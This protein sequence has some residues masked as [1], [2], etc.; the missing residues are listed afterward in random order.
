MASIAPVKTFG[1]SKGD[2]STYVVTWTPITNAD[3]CIA[4]SA[5]EYSDRSVHVSGTFGGTSIAVQGSNN[6]GVSFAS[7]NDPTSTVIAITTEAIKAILENTDQIK[8][9]RSGGDGTTSITVSM[10]FHLSNPLR[11]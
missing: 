4:W 2:G 7:L 9:V 6:A 11:Q 8:P 1:G 10:L 3:Q 5:P